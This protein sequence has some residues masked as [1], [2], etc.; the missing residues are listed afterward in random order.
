MPSVFNRSL[1]IIGRHAKCREVIYEAT[2]KMI[3][4]RFV[5]TAE[6]RAMRTVIDDASSTS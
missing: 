1:N 2:L 6:P 3:R 4:A 5:L